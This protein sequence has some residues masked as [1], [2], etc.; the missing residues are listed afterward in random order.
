MGI[1]GGK[2]VG[3]WGGKGIGMW[4]GKGMGI[5]WDGNIS[6]RWMGWIGICGLL[7]DKCSQKNM[8]LVDY[9]GIFYISE[10]WI[11]MTVHQTTH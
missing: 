5:E 4:G 3:K 10:Y 1:W 2:G 7:E 8:V 11:Q 9:I 6:W